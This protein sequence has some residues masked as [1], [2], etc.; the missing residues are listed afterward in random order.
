MTDIVDI[1]PLTHVNVG[2]PWGFISAGIAALLALAIVIAWWVRRRRSRRPLPVIP[3]LPP[4]QKAMAALA[5]LQQQLTHLQV[6]DHNAVHR[7][8]VSI[9]EVIRVYVEEQF[10][11][12][13][14]DLTTEEIIARLRALG[15]DQLT[16]DAQQHLIR[17][18]RETDHV[19]F[20]D[21]QPTADEIMATHPAAVQFVTMTRPVA[22]T[23][24]GA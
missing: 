7:Y 1:K 13:A 10:G 21:H 8:Y 3:A 11:L 9:S 18:L 14:T 4:D 19:K 22:I 16:H 2:L 24:E 17:F 23:K 12:N 20:A 5:Q 15:S 6:H